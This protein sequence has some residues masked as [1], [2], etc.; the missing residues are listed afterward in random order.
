MHKYKEKL[1]IEILS[2]CLRP[3]ILNEYR[4]K[5]LKCKIEIF[6]KSAIFHLENSQSP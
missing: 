1:K 4:S 2:N 6:K 3:R 5:N